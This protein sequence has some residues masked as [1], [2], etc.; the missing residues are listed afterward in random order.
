MKLKKY[1]L[2]IFL[3][4]YKMNIFF[5]FKNYIDRTNFQKHLIH[6]EL[7]FIEILNRFL[8]NNLRLHLIKRLLRKIISII[9]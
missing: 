6:L 4:K 5:F 7:K 9:Y 2:K 8:R 3:R 1:F